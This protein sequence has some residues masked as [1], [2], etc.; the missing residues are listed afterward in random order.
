LSEAFRQKD[1]PAVHETNVCSTEKIQRSTKF[2]VGKNSMIN[3]I[4]ECNDVSQPSP[5]IALRAMY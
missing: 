4:P 1:A 3:E 5:A 2:A